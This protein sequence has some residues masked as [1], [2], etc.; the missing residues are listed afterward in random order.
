MVCA[1]LP[2]CI[3]KCSG[4]PGV[5]RILIRSRCS[6]L[7]QS[8]EFLNSQAGSAQDS[9]Q[10]PGFQV[11]PSVNGNG[12]PSPGRFVLQE[13][14]AALLMREDESGSVQGG[15]GLPPVYER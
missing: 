1:F 8:D 14:M 5:K 11:L 9:A 10:G 6:A 12:D 15:D 3:L 4:G 13:D 7:E 2:R